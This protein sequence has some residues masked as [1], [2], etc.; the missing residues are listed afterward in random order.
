M[1][2]SRQ[3]YWIGFPFPTPGDLPPRGIKPM[4][5]ASPALAPGRPKK[6]YRLYYLQ[7]KI[8]I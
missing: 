8:E 5:L 6:W 1:Q 2:F 3:E 7:R 4:S